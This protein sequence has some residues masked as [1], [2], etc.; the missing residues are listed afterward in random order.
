MP[1]RGHNKYKHG[2]S[3]TYK[4]ISKRIVKNYG[5][6]KTEGYVARDTIYLANGFEAKKQLFGAM[7][8]TSEPVPFD[9]LLGNL[10]L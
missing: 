2:S 10:L 5:K 6:V 7:T 9:G 1:C 4:E 8:K 3:D